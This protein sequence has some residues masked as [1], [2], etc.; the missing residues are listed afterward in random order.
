MPCVL[1]GVRSAFAGFVA[2]SL[3]AGGASAAQLGTTSCPNAD[4]RIV[5]LGDSLADGLWGSLY[6][7]FARCETMEVVRLTEVSDGLAKTSAKGWLERREDLWILLAMKS[8]PLPVS[9]VSNTV[10]SV[11]ATWRTAC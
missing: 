11:Q 5:V 2:L 10:A 1:N 6:R 3:A 9:P 4:V 7:S 8:L